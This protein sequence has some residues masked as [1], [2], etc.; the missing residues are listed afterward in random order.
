MPMS[1]DGIEWRRRRFT[2]AIFPNASS[3]SRCPRGALHFADGNDTF[4]RKESRTLPIDCVDGRDITLEDHYVLLLALGAIDIDHNAASDLGVARQQI[5][6]SVPRRTF[7]T[8]A[9]ERR[10]ARQGGSLELVNEPL[11]DL[12]HKLRW[13]EKRRFVLRSV[14]EVLRRTGDVVRVSRR[15]TT[16]PRHPSTTDAPPP[17][18]PPGNSSPA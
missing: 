12:A 11:T 18:P 2:E 15:R 16:S 17:H 6:E 1:S 7:P 8:V 10:R 13:L 5:S 9:Y 14:I 3:S 4:N